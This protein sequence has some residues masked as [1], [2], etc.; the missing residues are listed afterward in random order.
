MKTFLQSCLHFQDHGTVVGFPNAE[1][2]TGENLMYENCDIFIP[3]AVEGVINSGNA[4]KI[5][6]KVGSPTALQKY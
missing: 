1:P 5:Q 3:A 4:H 2:Y 6:A